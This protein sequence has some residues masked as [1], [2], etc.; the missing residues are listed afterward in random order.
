LPPTSQHRPAGLGAHPAAETVLA[1]TDNVC[2]GLQILFHALA[3]PCLAASDNAGIILIGCN[4]NIKF[5]RVN[6]FNQR[7]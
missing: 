3:S 1:L 4:Y 5:R 6:Y 2:W 7:I